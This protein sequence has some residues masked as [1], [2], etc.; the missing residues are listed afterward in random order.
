MAYDYKSAQQKRAC[1]QESG[2]DDS[3]HHRRRFFSVIYDFVSGSRREHR[4]KSQRLLK[5]KDK[6]S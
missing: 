3:K 4:S 2:R 5:T 1:Q 6:G